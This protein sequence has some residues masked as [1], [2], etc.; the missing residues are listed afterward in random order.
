M[1]MINRSQGSIFG[2]TGK[3]L[4]SPNSIFKAKSPLTQN[5]RQ[6]DYNV[7]VDIKGDSLK[8]KLFRKRIQ[9][10]EEKS[11]SPYVLKETGGMKDLLSSPD[12]GTPL[13]KNRS[14]DVSALIDLIEKNKD[15]I[16]KA[17]TDSKQ[18][19][20]TAADGQK[21]IQ[22]AIADPSKIGNNDSPGA[23]LSKTTAA[24]GDNSTPKTPDTMP[25]LGDII[26]SITGNSTPSLT[27]DIT[28]DIIFRL[29]SKNSAEKD[30][31]EV[32]NNTF[33][34]LARRLPEYKNLEQKGAFGLGTAASHLGMGLRII[35]RDINSYNKNYNDP[36]FFD[37]VIDS[38]Q[39]AKKSLFTDPEVK[40]DSEKMSVVGTT[41]LIDYITDMFKKGKTGEVLSEGSY[42]DDSNT[43]LSNEFGGDNGGSLATVDDKALSWKYEEYKKRLTA[44]L[45]NKSHS[46]NYDILIS[47]LQNA[48]SDDDF[49]KC[50][51]HL[52]GMVYQ[53]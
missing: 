27:P 39:A 28:A 23:Q 10:L 53:Q 45:D 24:S 9:L 14:D 7:D 12:T 19:A 50:L 49:N 1:S 8:D 34:E 16:D 38:L 52:T 11:K 33:S 26:R 4:S 5:Q 2:F 3:A 41:S 43:I 22:D 35:A 37:T 51:N 15:A 44:E 48:K 42:W 32:I 6:A 46:N 13:L 36:S 29:K 40:N 17:D 21:N 18:P 20:N 25:T 31:I 47:Y 30:I